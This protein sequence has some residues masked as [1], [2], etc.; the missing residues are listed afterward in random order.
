MAVSILAPAH[1]ADVPHG[2][3]SLPRVAWGMN[4][5]AEFADGHLDAADEPGLRAIARAGAEQLRWAAAWVAADPTG[6]ASR[7]AAPWDWTALDADVA[8]A[9]RAGLRWAPFACEPPAAESRAPDASCGGPPTF[10]ERYARFVAA[11]AA[12]YGPGGAFW[13]AHPR[14]PA[15]PIRAVTVWNEPNLF[16]AW[17]VALGQPE[18]PEEYAALYARTRD[19]VA[20]S[21]GGRVRV[22]F[23][24]PAPIDDA[25]A[26]PSEYGE[27][28]FVRRAVAALGGSRVDAFEQ[29]PYIAGVTAADPARHTLTRVVTFRAMLRQIGRGDVPMELS[30]LGVASSYAFLGDPAV[31]PEAAVRLTE[32]QRAAYYREVLPAL[33]SS[34]CRI[35]S[36]SPLFF[37]APAPDRTPSSPAEAAVAAIARVFAI[38]DPPGA[39]RP[40]GVAFRDAVPGSRLGRTPPGSTNLCG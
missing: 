35:A 9:A 11:L 30:E 5:S 22:D 12:R 31:R 34:N 27:Q 24:P 4:A 3:P 23:A 10:H 19:A 1:L 36:I 6:A 15:L 7:G 18:M 16:G 29:H 8:T 39:L 20:A 13:R 37:S 21:V 14:L 32:D 25:R 40:A 26:R 33:A 2:D 17:P 38:A 28:Q